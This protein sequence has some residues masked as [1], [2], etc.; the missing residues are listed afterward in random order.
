VPAATL[1]GVAA[2]SAARE[3]KEE[4]N[5]KRLAAGEL[6]LDIYGMRPKLEEA[7]LRYVDSLDD[8]KK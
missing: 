4:T 2:A 8:L 7:G 3:K 6:G 5:R 1:A